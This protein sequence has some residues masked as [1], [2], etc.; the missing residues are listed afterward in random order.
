MVR[1]KQQH[2]TTK[3]LYVS[4]AMRKELRSVVLS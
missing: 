2:Y 3:K 4:K 1:N